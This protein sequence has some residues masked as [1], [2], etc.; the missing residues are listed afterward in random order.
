MKE[1]FLFLKALPHMGKPP[2]L[3]AERG[4]NTSPLGNCPPNWLFLQAEEIP[5]AGLGW[6]GWGSWGCSERNST[7]GQRSAQGLGARCSCP[8]LGRRRTAAAAST[9]HWWYRGSPTFG[10][11]RGEG[12]GAE[13]SSGPMHT[14]A[15]CRR[16]VVGAGLFPTRGLAR[17]SRGAQDER[18]NPFCRAATE[19]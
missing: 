8:R 1:I 14:A 17:S 7:G 11:T 3:L 12:A 18:S 15:F 5:F 6:A 2:S 13:H 10:E 9:A 16:A 19:P 4:A